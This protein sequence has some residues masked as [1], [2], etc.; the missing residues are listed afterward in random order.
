ME[1]ICLTKWRQSVSC[2]SLALRG[3]WGMF[4]LQ[5]RDLSLCWY[6]LGSLMSWEVLHK[7]KFAIQFIFQYDF[8]IRILALTGHGNA[9]QPRSRFHWWECSPPCNACTIRKSYKPFR[10][11]SSST[12]CRRTRRFSPG[13][14]ALTS[15]SSRQMA[16]TFTLVLLGIR[17]RR[18]SLT[19]S[20]DSDL[21]IT[22]QPMSLYLSIIGIRKDA[23]GS[24]LIGAT[25]SKYSNNVD[26]VHQ[27][28]MLGEIF[29]N[30]RDTR[31][32]STSTF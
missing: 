24:R 1:R 7:V 29:S 25:A 22:T 6:S 13:P 31:W 8:I 4:S 17:S 5:R 21:P 11:C 27:L 14:A 28:Q 16:E 23:I 20:P 12:P 18:W 15:S 19:M 26:P 2:H 30:C 9:I 32:L 3:W 10:T